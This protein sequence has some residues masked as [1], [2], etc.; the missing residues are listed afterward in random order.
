MGTDNISL[1]NIK[2]GSS[3]HVQNGDEEDYAQDGT[4]VAAKYMGTVTDQ[5]EM[6]VL[7][8]TQVL[9]VRTSSSEL[10]TPSLTTCRGTFDS[11]QFSALDAL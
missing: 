8:R 9:R 1:G 6:S 2:N 11:S 10:G 5:R 7:G 3:T 4:F